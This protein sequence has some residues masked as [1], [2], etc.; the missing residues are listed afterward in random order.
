MSPKDSFLV[1]TVPESHAQW[2]V[3]KFLFKLLCCIG[4]VE[5]SERFLIYRITTV[6]FQ[7]AIVF[8]SC[9]IWSSALVAYSVKSLKVLSG[10]LSSFLLALV[11]YFAMRRKRKRLT[12]T[13]RKLSAISSLFQGKKI[14]FFL[15]IICIMPAVYAISMALTASHKWAA[16]FDAYGYEIKHPLAQVLLIVT[17]SILYA[18]VYPTL[19][20]LITLIYCAV[21]RSSSE[22]VKNLTEDI[23][24]ISPR[25]FGP[26]KQIDILDRKARIDDVLE[27]IQDVFS[28]PA[29]FV[30]A[31]NFTSCM[32]IIG[33]FLHIDLANY[34]AHMFAQTVFLAINS[35]GC[36]TFLLWIASCVPI[37]MQKLKEAFYKKAHLRLITYRD[38]GEPQLKTELFQKPDFTFTGWDLIPFKRS[39]LVAVFG[40]LLS[41]TVLLV[42]NSSPQDPN[43]GSP[44]LSQINETNI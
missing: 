35:F 27:N 26:S 3:S 14:A 5:E 19:T 29:F 9:S 31:A 42:A 15:L 36:L 34:H 23:L 17:K 18:I 8:T 12:L 37:Q 16:K 13:L 6:G 24:R 10:K 40:T 1:L 20:N 11:V 25:A 22:L 39:T 38:L 44:I 28:L 43:L 2:S 33:W 21:C 32:T 41:Y 30:V 7:L 4:L